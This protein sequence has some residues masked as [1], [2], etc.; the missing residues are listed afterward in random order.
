MALKY[1]PDKNQSHHAE[2]RFKEISAAYE[3]LSDPQ[4]RAQYDQFGLNGVQKSHS[5]SR[6]PHD[7]FEAFFGGQNPFAGGFTRKSRKCK[8]V[9]HELKVSL[10]DL[11][12]GAE[13]QLAIGRKRVCG[14]CKGK[15]GIGPPRSCQTCRGTGISVGSYQVSPGM[16]QQVQST[17]KDCRGEGS[18]LKS[19]CHGCHGKKILPDK[20][21]IDVHIEKGMK[22]GQTMVFKGA[23]DESPGLEAGDLIIKICE[24]EHDVFTRKD[25]DLF[26]SLHVSLNEALTGFSRKLTLLDGRQIAVKLFP[27]EFVQHEGLKVI[28]NEGMPFPKDTLRKGNL[29]IKCIVEMPP[30][31]FFQDPKNLLILSKIL[32]PK[33]DQV[34]AEADT[35]VKELLDF[36]AQC[37]ISKPPRQEVY[38]E[39]AQTQGPQ[40]VQCQTQ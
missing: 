10:N 7:I 33:H 31:D 40:N 11:Y 32:P 13:K 28:L 6:D 21:V 20:K 12:N 3:I 38:E 36:D 5:Q 15:G 16:V 26:L 22:T 29:V 37:H 34:P 14:E 8:D 9:I 27:G 4:K 23:A 1:H 18:C 17:C 2:E 39:D 30:Q 24:K 19:R 35:E 25:H